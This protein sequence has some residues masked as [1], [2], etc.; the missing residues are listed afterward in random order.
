MP[1]ALSLD[2]ERSSNQNASISDASQTGLD[3]TGDLT[4]EQWMK[5]EQLPSTA[6]GEFDL[7]SKSDGASDNSYYLRINSSD[8]VEVYYTSDG[9]FGSITIIV[10]D[11]AVLL[12]SDV[13]KWVHIAVAVDVSAQVAYIY[14]N[15]VLQSSAA[16]ATGSTS[17]HDSAQAVTIG[18]SGASGG[19]T[20]AKIKDVRVWNDIRTGTEIADNMSVLTLPSTTNLQARWLFDG[21]YLDETSNNND[22]TGGNSPVFSPDVPFFPADF[23]SKAKI[24]IDNTKVSGSSDL[25]DFSALFADGNFIADVYTNAKQFTDQCLDL[26]LSS[27]QYGSISDASQ[28]GLDLS[29]DFTWEMWVK[30][31]STPTS[32]QYR[33]LLSKWAVTGNQRGYHFYYNNNGG[34]LELAVDLSGTGSTAETYTQTYTISTSQWTHI[35]IS[36]D[37]SASLMTFYVNGVPIGTDTGAVTSIFN[38][39]AAFAIGTEPTDLKYFDGKIKDVRVWNDIRTHKEIVTNMNTELLGNESGLVGYWKF[40]NSALDETSNNN[41]LTLSGSPSYATDAPRG[42]ADLRFTTD[43]AGTTEIPC[44]IVSWD[45]G[46]STSEVW[47]KVPTVSY[48]TDTDVYVWYN[49]DGANFRPINDKM[50]QYGVWPHKLVQHLNTSSVDS[51]ENAHNGTD[52]SVT[53]AT[54]QI[55]NGAVLNGSSS[56]IQMA[57]HADFNFGTGNFTVEAWIDT[58]TIANYDTIFAKNKATS[59]DNTNFYKFDI[60]V[61]SGTTVAPRF[62]AAVSSSIVAGYEVT[63]PVTLNDGSPHHIVVV[64]NGTSLLIYFDGVSQSLTTVTAISTNNISTG[65]NGAFIIGNDAG[66]TPRFFDGTVDEFRVILSALSADWIATEYANQNDPSTFATGDT[67]G[68]NYSE[69]LDEVVTLAETATKQTGK[70]VNESM[71]LVD[72]I[73]RELD[74]VLSEVITLTSDAETIKIYAQQLDDTLTLVDETEVKVTAKELFDTLTLVDT[75]ARDISRNLAETLVFVDTATIQKQVSAD[76]LEDITLVDTLTKQIGKDLL[77]ILTL[78]ETQT[79]NANY[80]RTLTETATL[81]D[82][83]TKTA[84]KVVTDVLTLV[85]T[86]TKVGAFAR[87]LSETVTLQERFQGLINGQNIAW[88]RKYANQAGTFIKKYLDIP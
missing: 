23:T 72:T 13:G 65:S 29:G 67:T 82:T 6:G 52:T 7:I 9:S 28:T 87:S 3:I 15:G 78:V 75:I 64:R 47:V 42:G 31:E 21:D 8:K 5:I 84:E 44:E 58:N 69:E 63:T 22:L 24:T 26:E 70:A 71:V 17:I 68:T 49:N 25:T 45:A 86:I 60:G 57:D 18:G 43:L 66:N 20:D 62:Y 27:S 85:D 19:A 2:L 16:S 30:P 61:V 35:A 50:G 88:F 80:T 14:K 36:W 12:S 76:L 56:I 40:D 79:F 37:A 53:Y 59:P 83:V 73:A 74:R 54:G 34:T 39:T 46:G 51:T 1:Q 33:F 41:D 55:K 11:N 77:D 32:G 4:F 10:S 38:N 48:N 81:V